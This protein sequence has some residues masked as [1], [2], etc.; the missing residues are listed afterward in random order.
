MRTINKLDYK[1]QKEM[2]KTKQ[3]EYFAKNRERENQRQRQH[4]KKKLLEHKKK[5]FE[6]NKIPIH[7]EQRKVD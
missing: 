2:R 3:K 4:R 5:L 1:Q 7:E 6:H